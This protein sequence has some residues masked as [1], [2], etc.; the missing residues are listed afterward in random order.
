MWLGARVQALNP[1]MSH[2]TRYLFR[3]TLLVLAVVMML[4]VLAS[5]IEMMVLMV[6]SLRWV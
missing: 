1:S 5:A 2:R 3:I 6:V 4:T